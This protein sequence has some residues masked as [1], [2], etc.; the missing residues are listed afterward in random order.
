MVL[1]NT[2]GT[3]LM[4]PGTSAIRLVYSNSILPGA[5]SINVG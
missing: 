5:E 1:R 3:P 4:K 2:V